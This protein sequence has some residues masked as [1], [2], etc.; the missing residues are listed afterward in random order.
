MGNGSGMMGPSHAEQ[1]AANSLLGGPA[2]GKPTRNSRASSTNPSRPTLQTSMQQA[3]F[4]FDATKGSGS[5]G[6]Q[7]KNGKQFVNNSTS[8]SAANTPLSVPQSNIQMQ[9][10]A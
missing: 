7:M 9:S 6:G 3:Q 8:F 10:Q 5:T 2:N 1:N 4:N